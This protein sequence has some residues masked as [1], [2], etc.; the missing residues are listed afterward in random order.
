MPNVAA[1]GF[2]LRN[3]GGQPRPVCL[4]RYS[5]IAATRGIPL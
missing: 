4:E 2:S 3:V 1:A 5:D